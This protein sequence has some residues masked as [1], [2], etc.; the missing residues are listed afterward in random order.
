MQCIRPAMGPV[1]YTH[2][3]PAVIDMQA[4]VTP[5][6]SEELRKQNQFSFA[7][8]LG[9]LPIQDSA[10]RP[11]SM[12][13]LERI[14]AQFGGQYPKFVQATLGRALGFCF[15]DIVPV[16]YTHLDVYKRQHRGC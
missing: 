3:S 8:R 14:R 11:A 6:K 15:S 1:S 13:V 9:K 7:A 5:G 10:N 2:L 4:V 16:S 12:F